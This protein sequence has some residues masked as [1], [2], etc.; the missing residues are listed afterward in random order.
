MDF[1][2][3]IPVYNYKLVDLAKELIKQSKLISEDFEL[4]IFDDCSTINQ[5]KEE[6]QSLKIYPE[7]QLIES[8][9]NIGRAKARNYLIEKAESE[10][11][12]FLDA[13][14]YPRNDQFVKDYLA[15]LKNYPVVVGGIQYKEEKPTENFLL[16]WKYGHAVES[17]TAQ[18]RKAAPYQSFMTTAFAIRKEIASQVQFE[19]AITKYGHEDTLFGIELKRNRVSIQHIDNPVYHVLLEKNT[20]FIEKTNHGIENLVFLQKADFVKMDLSNE[21]NLLR[22]H[23]RIKKFKLEFFF[24]YLYRKH[25][26][27]LL[28]NM[29][30]QQPSLKIFS[31]YKLAYLSFLL[32][33]E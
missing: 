14:T 27:W 13:D 21:V 3:C 24:A 8:E 22:F 2:I 4:L 15:A 12:I 6:N 9:I 30:S 17:K 23:K 29:N 10:N 19:G 11:L 16:R 1:S 33:K 18:I 28:G 7:V 5:L 25:K 31:L 26:K 20:E 32:S